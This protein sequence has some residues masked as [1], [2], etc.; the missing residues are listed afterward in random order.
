MKHV[1]QT[2]NERGFTLIEMLIVI[3]IIGV[4]AAIAYPTYTQFIER[5]RRADARAVLLEAA[6]FM[7]RRFTESRSYVGITLPTS[8][9]AAPREGAAW[10]SI[11]ASNLTATTYTLTATPRSG[12]TPKSC[13]SLSLDQLGVRAVSTS[14]AVADCW[15]R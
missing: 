4:L 13:G 2:E 15:Q 6:Q 3:A 7:E 9:S 5:A 12:W 11:A 1:R 10:Y 8:L 14:D